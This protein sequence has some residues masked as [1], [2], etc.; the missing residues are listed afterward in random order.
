MSHVEAPGD[1][2]PLSWPTGRRPRRGESTRMAH[3]DELRRLF[4]D[5]YCAWAATEIHAEVVA[6]FSR[7]R[8]IRGGRGVLLLEATTSWSRDEREAFLLARL[9]KI[10]NQLAPGGRSLSPRESELCANEIPFESWVNSEAYRETQR[11][12]AE[13]DHLKK[14]GPTRRLLR[15]ELT[16][17]LGKL[18]S[19][20][21]GDWRHTRSVGMFTLSTDF[22]THRA[23][24]IYWHTV[25]SGQCAVKASRISGRISLEGWLGVAAATSWEWI[26]EAEVPGIVRSIHDWSSHF[27]TAL[28]ALLEG[29]SEAQGEV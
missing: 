11:R 23:A 18:E 26:T 25:Y 1:L 6:D 21:G 10:R 24:I 17:L 16:P 13:G 5:R 8:S 27:L 22:I 7:L 15:A 29:L 9:K 19:R 14:W 20:D 2:A 4:A 12:I 3:M 28:P